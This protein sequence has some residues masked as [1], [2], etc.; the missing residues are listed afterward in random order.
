MKR[1]ILLLLLLLQ[2]FCLWAASHT[3]TVKITPADCATCND[4]RGEVKIQLEEGERESISINRMFKGFVLKGCTLD[5]KAIEPDYSY[6]GYLQYYITMGNH[7]SEMLVTFEYDPSAP[8]EP[9]A[10]HWDAATHRLVMD[11]FKAGELQSTI[12]NIVD[13][14]EIQELVVAGEVTSAD[15]EFVWSYD[16][17]RRL[18][19]SRTYGFSKLS[20][21]FLSS[22]S[23][24]P[25]EEIILPSCV[26]EI[27]RTGFSEDATERLQSLIIYAQVPPT[28]TGDTY[29]GFLNEQV[30][31]FV[32][33]PSVG[34]YAAHE[35][36]GKHMIVPASASMHDISIDLPAEA[37]DGRCKGMTLLL[38]NTASGERLKHIIT[39]STNYTFSGLPAETE[40]RATILNRYGDQV[41]LIPQIAL[42]KE[43]VRVAFDRL[44]SIHALEL[45][46]LA[47]DRNVSSQAGIS[48]FASDGVT[49][50]G[51]GSRIDGAVEG[52]TLYCQ[53]TLPEDILV[54][55]VQPA[56]QQIVVGP[57]HSI[58]VQLQA[59]SPLEVTGRIKAGG[60]GR[61]DAVVTMS[62]QLGGVVSRTFS[63]DVDGKGNFRLTA[64]N[65]PGQLVVDCNGCLSQSF[66]IAPETNRIDLGDIELKAM[67]GIVIAPE[68]TFTES[69]LESE[70]KA[71]SSI[72]PDARNVLYAIHNE[73]T[74]Q[75]V[76]D[77]ALQ[78]GKLIILS[79]AKAGDR[80][81]VTARH[82]KN[83]FVPV[84]AIAADIREGGDN[85]LR[86]GIT[87]LGKI[88]TSYGGCANDVVYALLFDADGQLVG[89]REYHELNT[90][91]NDVADGRYTLVS[92][93]DC[94][95]AS[96][97]SLDVLH[98][99][100]MHSGEHYAE[101]AVTV[102]S[103]LVSIVMHDLPT[104]D[105]SGLTFLSDAASFAA[106]K[107]S[108]AAGKYMTLTASIDFR[109][110][111]ANAVGDLSLRVGIPEGCSLV[112]NS[113]MVAGALSGYMKDGST[114]IVPLR[115]NLST[116]R[117]CV[118]PTTSG[119]K[120]LTAIAAFT[121]QGTEYKQ[122]VG[123]ADFG[124]N[125]I[126]FFVPEATSTT[127]IG[128]TGSTYPNSK[129]RVY[130]N[131]LL[132]GQTTSN[133][134]GDWATNVV[135]ADKDAPSHKF[136]VEIDTPNG[137]TLT[138]ETKNTVLNSKYSCPITVTM[139]FF[140][141]YYKK[142][143]NVIWNL[144]SGTCSDV[145]Y[146][147]NKTT[148]FTFTVDFSNP[149]PTLVS[150]VSLHVFTNSGSCVTLAPAYDPKMKAWVATHQFSSA[151]LPD[152][153]SVDYLL[154]M[155]NKID[156]TE[157]RNL[158]IDQE[159][160]AFV[161]QKVSEYVNDIIQSKTLLELTYDDLYELLGL[162]NP[163]N[164]RLW[165][166]TNERISEYTGEQLVQSLQDFYDKTKFNRDNSPVQ[167]VGEDVSVSL[168]SGIKMRTMKISDLPQD[169]LNGATCVTELPDGKGIY[170]KA[171]G[172]ALYYVNY[173]Q[174]EYMLYEGIAGS[175][176]DTGQMKDMASAQE[177]SAKVIE[178]LSTLLNAPENEHIEMYKDDYFEFLAIAQLIRELQ[179][180]N[181][182]QDARPRNSVRRKASMTKSQIDLAMNVFL[183]VNEDKTEPMWNRL[184]TET[185][186]A[187]DKID[188][189]I[190]EVPNAPWIDWAEN[191]GY[192]AGEVIE[193]TYDNLP[194]NVDKGVVKAFSRATL[195][196]D[197]RVYE[198]G[199]SLGNMAALAT[200]YF[201]SDYEDYSASEFLGDMGGLFLAS[202][203]VWAVKILGDKG[204]DYV[205]KFASNPTSDNVALM[206]AKFLNQ[207]LD[208]YLDYQ[209]NKISNRITYK[210]IHKTKK[211][212]KPLY[213]KPIKPIL[214]P[215]GYVYEAVASNRLQ[216][217]TASCYTQQ[218]V[219]DI[220]GDVNREVVLWD[221]VPY[222]QQNPLVTDE[223]GKYAWD[224]P[225]G[226]WQVKFEKDGYQTNYS[227]WLP[228]PPPQLEV[229]IPLSTNMPP[230][231]KEV[232]AY[233]EGVTV[234]FDQ[235]MKPASLNRQNIYV[236]RDGNLIPGTIVLSDEE[237][238]S[239]TDA[240]TY[241]SALRFVP[242]EPLPVGTELTLLVSK[243]V[244]NYSG[245]RMEDGFLQTFVVEPEVKSIEA[246]S[247]VTMKQGDKLQLTVRVMPAS[248]SVG[249]TLRVVSAGEQLVAATD[250]TISASGEAIVTLQS[251]QGIGTTGVLLSI[252]DTD[253]A[254]DVIVR[255]MTEDMLSQPQ[256]PQP[257]LA[258]G[259]AVYKGTKLTLTTTTP[260]AKIYYTADGASPT[261]SN[262]KRLLYERPI[263]IDKDVVIKA[264]CE[265]AN[266]KESDVTEL[267]Y[268]MRRSAA[269]A[270]LYQG[271][272]WIANAI[273]GG[274][275]TKNLPTSAVKVEDEQGSVE[276]MQPSRG[277]RVFSTD[278]AD[279]IYSGLQAV[280]QATVLHEGVNWIG[281]AANRRVRLDAA[282]ADMLPSEGDYVMSQSAFAVYENGFW[283]GTLRGLD[284]G[285]GYIY[286]TTNSKSVVMNDGMQTSNVVSDIVEM[287][288]AGKL[289]NHAAP[290][291]SCL[292]ATLTADGVTDV[293]SGRYQL[294]ARC[295]GDLR[296]VAGESNGMFWLNIST[297]GGEYVELIAYD[298]FDNLYYS[299]HGDY[300]VSPNRVTG[301]IGSTV[302]LTIGSVIDAIKQPV[303]NGWSVKL[304][305]DGT[306]TYTTPWS[307][308][309]S[310][311]VCD[312]MG[313][314]LEALTD[315]P[316]N[317]S[318][319]IPPTNSI[320][321]RMVKDNSTI[322]TKVLAR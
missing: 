6:D 316:A 106:Q 94:S 282:F 265:A 288:A 222:G 91:F 23:P 307:G 176:F 232:K 127:L 190:R 118:I 196:K 95:Y 227:E 122:P 167:I 126:E 77:F 230:Q 108:I 276:T 10:N 206:E 303:T 293:E 32:P 289:M 151:S 246:D 253:L 59:Y 183:K 272:T 200:I 30:T 155:D 37:V 157:Y 104:L 116:V 16:N 212:Q 4:K 243:Q 228:V 39:G 36:W 301:H 254:E 310:I 25:V 76:E 70:Q 199:E 242:S 72:Y 274:V 267:L 140:N 53:T 154:N 216:G 120:S 101:T 21:S 44:A 236:T 119:Q 264:V 79:G 161:R 177:H 197:L 247:I 74:G 231:V 9:N 314:T 18:D 13:K 187:R 81:K 207:A 256:A 15:L 309:E 209:L 266:G 258:S 269:D 226:M 138:S 132:V 143:I 75:P 205:K 90:T 11:H 171:V 20:G 24:V 73:T 46:L 268:D 210:L 2:S 278:D 245:I 92:M 26:E 84:S 221:A 189:A 136:H 270:R 145:S 321:V 128:A 271:W 173:D 64:L 42:G 141:Q 85:A 153:V 317:G 33:S 224:V 218:E 114:L 178:Y 273:E 179:A 257:S 5:G 259:T 7:D 287:P 149:D 294:L 148:D 320:I 311:Y 111:F 229:N 47:G 252:D 220:Y 305:T 280:P 315:L 302:K 66:D 45:N 163:D 63:A 62:Q 292:I 87:E 204:E 27:T 65:V 182:P 49:L 121:L 112:E 304:G 82:A 191:I 12:S 263:P 71:P 156:E 137:L 1:N 57:E 281:S 38:Q 319:H 188:E 134:N 169:F 109:S 78:Y 279:F 166:S 217:V 235:Y 193:K 238:V 291:A 54:G 69:V 107:S 123:T 68:F 3:L 290:N 29:Y 260:N 103:G 211:P 249:K 184:W 14:E 133:A 152:N 250:A 28:V 50:V 248:A 142:D 233:E 158:K 147:F 202:A 308:V 97:A 125:E 295:N 244:E 284:P 298:S 43:N 297:S 89:R 100:P 139:N 318:I 285:V 277:Y 175:M 31:I 102:Q 215:S 198:A 262:D 283:Q 17:L 88:H 83:L 208:S 40:Y 150:E 239:A 56:R 19:L 117:F 99:S 35:E 80:L 96:A 251:H 51:Y 113:V 168:G 131:T 313:R 105:P 306:L 165:E 192:Y 48:W 162:S 261:S 8:V 144:Q 219:E 129:V 234:R 160:S 34:M 93:A 322:V 115:D 201:T 214:D 255:V 240:T 203:G 61:Y 225:T 41:A 300:E 135:M 312:V 67:S 223:M 86:F 241:A 174:E 130:E 52:S 159:L 180:E 181:S 146:P 185:D 98:S 58:D 194:T 195:A 299:V 186:F 22:Y 172:N 213:P 55:Y 296:G 124:V 275:S 164:M 110:A 286:G 170:V 237:N 60:N